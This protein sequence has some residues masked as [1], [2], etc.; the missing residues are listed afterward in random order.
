MTSLIDR[1]KGYK[2]CEVVTERGNSRQVPEEFENQSLIKAVEFLHSEGFS[3]SEIS[4]LTWMRP[5]M[6]RN[7]LV[8]QTQ[9][10]LKLT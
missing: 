4:K 2:W 1:A 10:K 8:G 6:V 9:T 3:F 7:Y 5:Q